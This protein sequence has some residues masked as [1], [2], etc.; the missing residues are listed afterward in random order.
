MVHGKLLALYPCLMP[1]CSIQVIS[2]DSP[3][4]AGSPCP[5]SPEGRA[6]TP[7]CTSCDRLC[8]GLH[9]AICSRFP[10]PHQSRCPEPE[11]ASLSQPWCH[12]RHFLVW[13]PPDCLF[14]TCQQKNIFMMSLS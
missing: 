7:A 2:R 10:Y 3:A 12:T 9:E 13:R 6:G 1:T 5:A 4:S 14:R 11:S 8:R